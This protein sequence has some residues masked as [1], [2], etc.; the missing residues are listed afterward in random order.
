MTNATKTLAIIFVVLS[1]VTAGLKWSSGSKGSAAFTSELVSVDTA[2]VSKMVISRP[3]E[4]KVT[5]TKKNGA[6]KVSMG[7]DA[8]YPADGETIKR[9]IQTLN[10]LSVNA[11]ATRNPD[12]FA[13]YKV[14]DSTGT[15]V[16]LYGGDELLKSIFVGA[17]NRQGR[18]FN[19]Y[20]RLANQNSVYTVEGF[21]RPRFAKKLEDWREKTVWDVDQNNISRVDYMYQ[22]DSSFVMTKTDDNQWV[23]DGDTLSSTKASRVLSELSAPEVT[24][25]PKAPS[26]ENFGTETYALQIELSNGQKHRLRLKESPSDTTEYIGVS[27]DYPYVFSFRKNVWDENVLKSRGEL[28]KNKQ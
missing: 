6:W 8:S 25:F 22:A 20:V 16:S 2:K 11:V 5:L 3:T 4:P 1:V 13:R 26:K 12:K 24:G 28:L 17:Q 19:S 15:K 18:S 14:E 23:S 9:T 27:P 21:L 10:Q 7:S